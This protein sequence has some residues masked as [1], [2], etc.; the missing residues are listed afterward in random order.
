MHAP[1]LTADRQMGIEE[2][3]ILMERAHV[4]RLVVVDDSQV[5]PI[6]VISTS[7]LVRS[8]ARRPTDG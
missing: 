4:H 2:A 7:D 5:R 6:G 1:V 3:A 8:L